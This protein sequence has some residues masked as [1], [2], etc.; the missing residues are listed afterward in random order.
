MNRSKVLIS[1]FYIALV[2][3]L[4]ALMG[5]LASLKS[6][7]SSVNLNQGMIEGIGYFFIMVI[8]IGIIRDLVIEGKYIIEDIGINIQ[9]NVIEEKIKEIEKDIKYLEKKISEYKYKTEL[10]EDIYKVN[11]N[12]INR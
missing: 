6:A 1:N 2:T 9:K 12:E 11:V 10:L 8:G 7:D 4:V 5:C 3:L